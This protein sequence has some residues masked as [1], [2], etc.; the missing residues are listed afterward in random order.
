MTLLAPALLGVPP[1]GLGVYA[2]GRVG[3]EG[4]WQWYTGREWE[5][6][7]VDAMNGADWQAHCDAAAARARARGA[8]GVILD[9]EDRTPDAVVDA[10][11]AWIRRN[12]FTVRVGFTSYPSWNGLA[13]L[14]AGARGLFW[15]SPQLYFDAATNARGWAR[16]RSELGLRLI[17]SIA[18]YV[19]GSSS[20][21]RAEDIA[22]R[23]SAEAYARYLASV[24]RA[25]GAIAWP[26]WPVRPYMLQQLGARYGGVAMLAG[27]PYNV[28]SSLDTWTGL[29]LVLVLLVVCAAL[30]LGVTTRA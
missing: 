6:V 15:G 4:P 5:L 21:R 19:E 22:L 18:A 9:R 17:P 30:A 23:G 29:A 7:G 11:A 27:L 10:I 24:P 3:A 12:A 2:R 1:T 20:S 26:V 14:A 8:S 13:R 16:W 28:A 25:G